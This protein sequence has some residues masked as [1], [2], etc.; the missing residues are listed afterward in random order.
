MTYDFRSNFLN[1]NFSY[2]GSRNTN[3]FI[4]TNFYF[5]YSLMKHL[6]SDTIFRDT[7]LVGYSDYHLYSGFQF[8]QGN[9]KY[10]TLYDINLNDQTYNNIFLEHDKFKE[11]FCV[12]GYDN[13]ICNY[14]FNDYNSGTNLG[15]YYKKIFICDNSN[16][17]NLNS[18]AFSNI[19]GYKVGTSYIDDFM[20]S[21]KGADIMSYA[22]YFFIPVLL[23]IL[24][25]KIFRRGV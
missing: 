23:F 10:F 3:M 13:Y 17:C 16:N 22:F 18:S 8:Y 11:Q 25:I 4:Q 9:T 19:V 6:S 15:N 1:A 21:N 2:V 24:A 12:V 7:Y 20:F 5:S 14:V